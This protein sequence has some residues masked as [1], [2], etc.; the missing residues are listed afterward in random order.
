MHCKNL[1]L[2][3]YFLLAMFSCD[4]P[5]S[6]EP[7]D[8]LLNIDH[9]L[10]ITGSPATLDVVTW[11]VKEFPLLGDRTIELL[12]DLIRKISPDVIAFQEIRNIAGFKDLGQRLPGWKAA[13][14]EVSEMNPGFLYKTAEVTLIGEPLYLFSE[15]LEAFPRPPMMISIEHNSGLQI[16]LINIHLKCCSGTENESRRRNAGIMLKT[17]V[18]EKLPHAP[19][20]ILG[21]F[22]DEIVQEKPEEQVFAEFLKDSLKYRFIDH[23]IA[24]GNPELWSYPRWPSHLDHFLITDELYEMKL[25]LSVLAFDRC[26]TAYFTCISDHRP[27]IL[28]IK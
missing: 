12:T 21:D 27:L 22:N 7:T 1:F 10:V 28:R 2:A 25:D 19:V 6:E 20:L 3:F 26:D 23:D 4:V 24:N 9:C 15:E 8:Q 5:G 11:N 16:M 18:D 17:F 14:Q 13:I